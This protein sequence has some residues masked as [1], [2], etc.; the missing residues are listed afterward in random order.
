MAG[1]DP[2]NRRR[3]DGDLLAFQVPDQGLRAGV[4][5]PLGQVLA[6]LH[7]ALDHRRW[8]RGW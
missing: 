8:D 2:G 7:D 5:A 3:R 1:Q 4:Q 6:Q